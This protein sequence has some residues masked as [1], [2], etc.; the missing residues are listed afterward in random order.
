MYSCT[1]TMHPAPRSA[2]VVLPHPFS[3]PVSRL[4]REESERLRR[5]VLRHVGNGPDADDITQQAFVEMSC[6]Y[7]TFRGDSKPSTWLFGI[8]RNLIRNH[9]SRTPERR[10][11]FVGEDA[12][13]EQTDPRSDPAAQAERVQMIR[14]LDRSL[15]A[16]APDLAEMLV[17]ICA[18]ELSYEEVAAQLDLPVGTVRSRLSRARTQIR[19]RMRQQGAWLDD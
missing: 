5:F 1:V 2:A 4:V 17:M 3:E 18:D 7:D 11:D 19:T 15:A 10:Y 16:M 12:L 14:I 8:A 13:A 6:H 9:L